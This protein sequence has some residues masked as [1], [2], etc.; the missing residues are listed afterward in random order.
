[1]KCS[2]GRVSSVICILIASL[3]LFCAFSEVSG[4]K[5]APVITA[6]P[7]EDERRAV[8]DGAFAARKR[9]HQEEVRMGKEPAYIIK[10]RAHNLGTDESKILIRINGMPVTDVL[11]HN[12]TTLSF[13]IPKQL[14]L[15][16]KSLSSSVLEINIGNRKPRKL[17][18][19]ALEDIISKVDLSEFRKQI[20]R[21]RERRLRST[22]SKKAYSREDEGGYRDEG[23]NEDEDEDEEE[24]GYESEYDDEGKDE[25]ADAG[26][27]EQTRGRG[28]SG[29][30]NAGERTKEDQVEEGVKNSGTDFE[31]EGENVNKETNAKA[32]LDEMVSEAERLLLEGNRHDVNKATRMLEEVIAE[33]DPRA[34][35]ILGAALLSGSRSGLHRDVD[36]AIAHIQTAS[37]RGYPDAQAVL[38]FLYASGIA[39]SALRKDVGAAVLMWTFAAEGGSSYAKMALG[40]RYYTGTDV[41]E[42]CQRA[43]RYYKAVADEV[44]LEARETEILDVGNKE[45]VKAD[46]DDVIV[47]IR[48]P[49]ANVMHIPYQEYL[50]EGMTHRIM[51]EANEVMQFYRHSADRGDP[52]AQAIMGSLY[53]YGALGMPQDIHRARQL[54]TQAANGGYTGAHAHIGLMDLKAGE[55]K[56]AIRHLEKAAD[57]DEKLGLHG[58]GYVTLHGIGVQKDE[59][60]AAAYFSKAA[61]KDHPEAMFNLGIMFLRGIGLSQSA[62]HA[63]TCFGKAAAHYGHMQSHYQLGSMYLRGDYPAKKDCQRATYHLKYVAQKGVWNKILSTAFR[64]YE[65]SAYGDALFCYLRAAHA[66][67]ESAQHNAAFMYEHN[68]FSDTDAFSLNFWRLKHRPPWEMYTDRNA[69]VEEAL[70]LY[71][72]SA[73]QGHSNSMV[74]MGDLAFMEIKDFA[75]AASA[76]ERAV[77]YQNAEA[78]F[79]LGWMHARG[80][81]MSPDKHMAKRYFDQAKEKDP[82]AYIPA[83]IALFSLKYSEAV[84]AWIDKLTNFINSIKWRKRKADEGFEGS[85]TFGSQ[86]YEN[87]DVFVLSCLLG[88]LI[89]VLIVRRMRLISRTRR[90]DQHGTE[91]RQIQRE[92]GTAENFSQA[93]LQAGAQREVEPDEH[94]HRD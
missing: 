42:N 72:M 62:E 58:M 51:G 91:E 7:P 30:F 79:N 23:E 37:N 45:G 49:S 36:A 66:G 31:Q 87:M 5:R 65:R 90:R 73:S 69:V 83:S 27:N 24:D 9:A 93:A 21:E 6:S 52:R 35:T 38:G 12:E 76:Y 57:H 39:G 25:Y 88:I 92:G 67:I 40:Y 1:M 33:G 71:Q 4:K 22:K 50:T 55:N 74:R 63:F 32:R 44:F 80:F 53:Y 60:K 16:R 46:G 2:L 18:L 41:P 75:R 34:M 43:L 56:S 82:N 94:A 86:Q 64:A 28:E 20:M 29:S 13:L 59:E 61:A 14:A 3:A 84:F 70:D 89:P 78:M 48:P 26:E 15:D 17:P 10:L 8:E 81:G 11:L 85:K 19:Q 54:F 68:T 47:D 77:K